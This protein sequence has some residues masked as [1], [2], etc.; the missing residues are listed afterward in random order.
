MVSCIRCGAALR[1][2]S[3]ICLQCGTP[4]ATYIQNVALERG[5]ISGMQSFLPA[6]LLIGP[7]EVNL[8]VRGLQKMTRFYVDVLGLKPIYQS[9]KH[10][11]LKVAD[12]FQGHT[13]IVALFNYRCDGVKNTPDVKKSSLHHLAFE[14]PLKSFAAEKRR[15]EASGLEVTEVEHREIH[16]RSMY[17]DDPEGNQVELVSYDKRVT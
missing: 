13:Q 11:F 17:F 8:R 4:L 14:V 10:M 15:L 9:S 6:V 12:G 3:R 7:G 16:W 1:D 5:Q 2:E